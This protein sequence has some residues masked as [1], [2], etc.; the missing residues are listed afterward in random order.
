M[1]VKPF[2]E[3]VKDFAKSSRDFFSKGQGFFN[4]TALL[5]DKK[6]LQWFQPCSAKE[7][8]LKAAGIPGA[9]FSAL[10]FAIELEFIGAFMILK[11]IADLVSGNLR[12]AGESI[13]LGLAYCFPVPILM[14]VASIVI[15]FANLIDFIGAAHATASEMDREPIPEPNM[16]AF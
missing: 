10:C 2:N 9:P 15:F 16:P 6:K 3:E 13:G 11:S 1:S 4:L 8:A 5:D 14:L 12:T 7:L